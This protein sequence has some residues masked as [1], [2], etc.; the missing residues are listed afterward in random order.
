MQRLSALKLV[1]AVATAFLFAAQAQAVMVPT[2]I[3]Q[4]NFNAGLPG[5]MTPVNLG[6]ND[7]VTGNLG[8]EFIGWSRRQTDWRKPAASKA[9]R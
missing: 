1:V 8:G 2:L 5:D 6:P 9:F 4:Q 3:Y 7:A